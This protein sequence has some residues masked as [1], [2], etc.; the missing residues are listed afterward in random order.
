MALDWRGRAWLRRIAPEFGGGRT[1]RRRGR[2]TL[3]VDCWLRGNYGGGLGLPECSEEHGASFYSATGL[4]PRRWIRSTT[5]RRCCSCRASWRRQAC[6]D[7]HVDKHGLFPGAAG[8]RGWLGRRRPR[9]SPLPT[10]ACRQGSPDGGAVGRQG[11]LGGFWRVGEGSA[12]LCKRARARGGT[13]RGR[14]CD[15]ATR[16][17][18]VQNVRSGR[19]QSTHGTCSTKC[20]RALELEGGA[21][22]TQDGGR[23]S[24]TLS[25][26]GG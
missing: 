1:G 14:Q 3:P 8:A 2:R 13:R 12:W 26:Q 21:G 23:G 16:C 22:T 24:K 9:Q 6:A 25:G 20:Q 15:A 4:A 18:S 7:E 19:A 10:P 17:A 11:W 5:G